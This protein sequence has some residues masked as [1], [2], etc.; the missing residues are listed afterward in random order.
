MNFSYYDFIFYLHQYFDR[1]AYLFPLGI[2]G[3]WRWCVWLLKDI[4]GHHYRP[5]TG[6]YDTNVSVITPVYNEDPYIFEKVIESWRKNNPAEIIAVIDY[7]DTRCIHI[8]EE[9]ARKYIGAKLIITKKPGKR[10]ALAD[11]IRAASGDVVA[12]VDSDTLW[13][14]TTLRHGLPPFQDPKVGGVGTYQNVLAPKTLAQKIFDIQLDLRYC[15]EYPF[16]AAAGDALICLSGR[17]AFYRRDIVLPML[18]DLEYETFFGK[19]VISG[20]DKRLTYL[21]LAAGWKVAYQSNSH[22][23]TPGM[24]D[25][26]SY[27]KQRLRWTRN[28]LRADMRALVQG[29]PL[30][31]PAL[32]FFQIDK[33]LQSFVVILSPIY[34]FI[35]L[36][37]HM[38]MGALVIALWWFVS[39]AV[40]MYPHLSRKPHN[41]V[42][43]PAYILFSFLMGVMKIYAFFTLNTQGWITRWDK[44]RL[45]QLKFLSSLPA[46]GATACVIFILSFGVYWY[47]QYTYYIP[48]QKNLS[49]LSQALPHFVALSSLSSSEQNVLGISTE[50]E[51]QLHSVRYE[52]KS[53]ESIYTVATKFKIDPQRLLLANS[54]KV[55]N[56]GRLTPGIYLSV[57]EKD[58]VIEKIKS[59]NNQKINPLP[60]QITYDKKYNTIVINGRGQ[61]VTLS[62]IKRYLG[63]KY[64][65]ETFPKIWYTNA[66]IYVDTGVTLVLDKNEVTWLKLESNQNN[67][68]NI[69]AYSG[70]IILS[71]VKVTSWDSSKNSY[72]LDTKDKRSFIMAKDGGRMDIIDSE[73]AYLGYPTSDDL[74]VSPYGVS[75]K[76]GKD[77][78]KKALL[79]GEVINSKFHNNYFGAYTFGATGMIWRGNEFYDNI[80][81]G[82]DPHDDSNGFLVENNKAYNNGTHGIIFSKRCMYN[83]VRN[84][85][86]YNNKLHGIMLHEQSNHNIIE[87][88]QVLSNTSGIALWRSSDNVVRNNI[89]KDNRH[90]VRLN[91]T[92]NNNIIEKNDILESELYGIY[93][94]D[95]AEHNIFASNKLTDN[96]VGIYMKSNANE[97]RN[98]TLVNNRTGI[99]FVESASQNRVANN[100]V[101]LSTTYGIYTKV[102]PALQNILGINDFTY[103]RKNIA[104]Q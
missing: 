48:R 40:K 1:Y 69:R 90:G 22:V 101:K 63:D 31:Y 37:M 56:A 58:V 7:T 78:L 21:V 11:G 14:A 53:G 51:K 41:V 71:G 13:T 86:T 25:M 70:D 42:L 19:P 75:W 43:I 64:L 88:N 93:V 28:A 2:I 12:L 34:F 76:L 30:R 95:R 100:E 99:Y 15:F 84:N 49:R 46:Y 80:D 27:L 103:N 35:S 62:D 18:H 81:Y 44:S 24:K 52:T 39:R 33:F 36:A 50:I 38:W 29:W 10:P 68:V 8:F 97:I 47:K 23:Y 17:T 83:V 54:A 66:S 92:S 67:F 102:N 5:K 16:L 74:A 85:L 55:P 73:L 57:P 20:D 45:P 77:N 82:L 32:L 96:E 104:G 98:N 4:V 79:T 91:E 3:I 65:K 94:Y 89:L 59:Y 60:V 6:S 9:F 87:N 26:K 72:D 61:R